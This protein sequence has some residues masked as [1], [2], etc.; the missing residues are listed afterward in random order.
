VR[1]IVPWILELTYGMQ[2]VYIVLLALCKA[3]MLFFFLRIFPTRRMIIAS[4]IALG[5]VAMWTISFVFASI[6]FCTPISAQW[7]NQGKCGAYI[8]F[9][10]SIIATNAAG[11]LIIM[12]M[13]MQ[14]LWTLQ[15]RTQEKLAI[16]LCFSLA[17]ACVVC[18]IFRIVYISTVDLATNI[19]G[20][21]P[22]TIFLFILEPNLAILCVSIPML[23]PV[24]ARVKRQLGFESTS[25]AGYSYGSAGYGKKSKL[26]SQNGDWELKYVPKGKAGS[27]DT[28]VA[29]ADDDCSSERNLTAPMGTRDEI[30]IE[31]TWTVR[32]E[33]DKV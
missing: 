1:R 10:Q 9:I 11:D 29:R 32:H 27:N 22:T 6:F 14:S 3:S 31:T 8:P 30:R 4:K 2:P 12:A 20:T 25:G 5:I 24:F 7:T 17:S 18:A 19:T 13:P 23:R 28:E 26:A 21:M 33:M 15:K 16:M